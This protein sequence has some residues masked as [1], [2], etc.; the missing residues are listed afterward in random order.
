MKRI[1][2]GGFLAA[3]LIMLVLMLS[4]LSMGRTPIDVIASHKACSP[5]SV[6]LQNLNASLFND[7]A[8]KNAPIIWL[9]SKNDTPVGYALI[10]GGNRIIY[11][12][13]SDYIGL[14]PSAMTWK[15][16]PIVPIGSV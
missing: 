3:M 12:N 9:Q 6:D 13:V 1:F 7:P 15:D 11:Q 2:F 8:M 14:T 4:I 16:A 10:K 5:V